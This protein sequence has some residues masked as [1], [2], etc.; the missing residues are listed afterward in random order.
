VTVCD[1]EGKI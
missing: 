1:V